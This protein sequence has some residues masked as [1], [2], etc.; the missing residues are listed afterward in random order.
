MSEACRRGYSSHRSATPATPITIQVADS[1]AAHTG[2]F[3]RVRLTAWSGATTGA[4]NSSEARFT[5]RCFEAS[6][7]RIMHPMIARI[8]LPELRSTAYGLWQSG[9]ERLGDVL[10]T[11]LVGLFTASLGLDNVL[12]YMVSGLVLI[13]ALIWFFIYRTY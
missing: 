10:F 11:L 8:T 6:L 4:T 12:L 1:M 3:S 2:L 9:S 13:R 5:V 7:A